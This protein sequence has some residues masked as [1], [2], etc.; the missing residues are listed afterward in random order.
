MTT[1]RKNL[2]LKAATVLVASLLFSHQVNAAVGNQPD[3]ND[4]CPT[5]D[6]SKIGSGPANSLLNNVAGGG[7]PAGLNPAQ[8]QSILGPLSKLPNFSDIAGK[9]PLSSLQNPAGGLGNLGNLL[10]QS[11]L[12]QLA[13]NIGNLGDFNNLLNGGLLSPD[14]LSQFQ[15]NVL[16]NLSQAGANLTAPF[17]TALQQL[18]QA[19]TNFNTT[20]NNLTS[21]LQNSGGL[22]NLFSGI[23]SQI[24]NVTDTFNSV[25]AQ[26][27]Q[28]GGLTNSFNS[29][30]SSAGSQ[31][32]NT[33]NN[34]AQQATQGGQNIASTVAS[35]AGTQNFSSLIGSLNLNSSQLTNL[36]NSL[37]LNSSQLNQLKNSNN[38]ASTLSG[39]NLPAATITQAIPSLDQIVPASQVTSAVAGLPANIQ[40][41]ATS[42]LFAGL[43]QSSQIGTIT[44][45]FNGLDSSAKLPALTSVFSGLNPTSQLSA[46]QNTFQQLGANPTAQI[47]ALTNAFGQLGQS[48]AAAL[49][50]V[51]SDLPQQLQTSIFNSLLSNSNLSVSQLLSKLPISPEILGKLPGFNS[52][53]LANTNAAATQSIVGAFTSGT[54]G[55]DD[56]YKNMKIHGPYDQVNN[57]EMLDP[58]KAPLNPTLPLDPGMQ[59]ALSGAPAIANKNTPAI[60][61]VE[62]FPWMYL[63]LDGE[64]QNPLYR[65]A[66]GA[67]AAARASA[68]TVVSDDNHLDPRLVA[69]RTAIDGR[70]GGAEALNQD[71]CKLITDKCDYS[72]ERIQLKLDL[73]FVNYPVWIRLTMDSCANQYILPQGL[74][75]SYIFSTQYREHQYPWNESMCQ[76]LAM[77]KITCEY[78]ASGECKKDKGEHDGNMYDYRAWGYLK[79]AYDNVINK[80]YFP[81][82]GVSGDDQG[83]NP[84]TND[85]NN[86]KLIGK[87]DALSPQ[88]SQTHQQK[89]Q[90]DI[91]DFGEPFDPAHPGGNNYKEDNGDYKGVLTMINDLAEQPFERIFDPTHPYSPRWDWKGTDRLYSAFA[92]IDQSGQFYPQSA[93]YFGQISSLDGPGI[94]GRAINSPQTTPGYDLNAGGTCTVRC[95]AV[96][97][98]ILT[99]RA[100]GFRE[101]ITCRINANNTC[102]WA[103]VGDMMTDRGGK[104]CK[105]YRGSDVKFN[106]AYQA[107]LNNT[108]PEDSCPKKHKWPLCPGNGAAPQPGNCKSAYDLQGK[109]PVCSTKF[110]VK[111]DNV[112]SLCKTCVKLSGDKN[113]NGGIKKCCD[114]LARALSGINTLKLRN[115]KENPALEP[116]PEG[117]RFSDYFTGPSQSLL[118]GGIATPGIPQ[119][120]VHMPYMRW[121]DTGTAA[122]GSTDKDMNNNPACDLGSYDVIVGVG[123]DGNKGNDGA[124]YCRFGGNGKATS[125]GGDNADCYQLPQKVDALTSWEELKQYQARAMRD[126]TLFCLPQYEKMYKIMTGEDAALYAAGGTYQ[127]NEIDIKDGAKRGKIMPF[128]I[129]W[130]GYLTDTDGDRFPNFNGGSS[131][132]DNLVGLDN[133]KTGDII[134]LNYDDVAPKKPEVD[135]APFVAVVK[136]TNF[137]YNGGNKVDKCDDHIIAIT[138]NNGKLPDVC[139]NT[140]EYGRGQ[141]RKIYKSHLPAD[142]Y[143][144]LYPAGTQNIKICNPTATGEIDYSVKVGI[145]GLGDKYLAF[146]SDGDCKDPKL[147]TCM[148]DAPGYTQYSYPTQNDLWNKVH[149]YRPHR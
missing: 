136:G 67:E 91:K 27:Q 139:G 7:N 45:L 34:V 2:H 80:D 125:Y 15:N 70:S 33:F 143:E 147:G 76:P 19:G 59:G 30:L 38:V 111:Q 120:V 57:L 101:C 29:L 21:Q 142:V 63:V 12:D 56:R 39:F 112:P 126:L 74:N 146:Q 132:G 117:Y 71:K 85:P 4:L 86:G 127:L 58:N 8:L 20:F 82:G 54:T 102:F 72:A 5:P 73:D 107:T 26:A 113:E 16:N 124:K 130:L 115:T 105:D 32:G 90:K 119:R 66:G 116:V 78:D 95:G 84:I 88:D 103:Q 129:P 60:S 51:I 52:L 99:F 49:Q 47:S 62:N 100:E 11:G 35:S 144:K 114:N 128:P 18:Q 94:T 28:G 96:P 36:G 104:N 92:N 81:T 13:S 131:D 75:A 133:A 79:L 50:S 149:I 134:Y 31:L 106:T 65:N 24:G 87:P 141:E 138:V 137:K 148:F 44:G 55:K 98:D 53:T 1:I 41:V 145:K 37:N 108:C 22:G 109:W 64:S 43:P 17:N 23:T 97:V 140:D 42:A 121:W 68:M 40:Q 118:T 122:G 93:T 135:T 110:D 10:N 14:Q 61:L 83:T 6:C 9:I 46:V 69:M 3:P 77:K 25:L 123:V 89:V 48:Q